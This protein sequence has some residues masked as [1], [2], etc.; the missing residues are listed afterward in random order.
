MLRRH[1]PGAGDAGPGR[2]GGGGGRPR[3]MTTGIRWRRRWL[4]SMQDGGESMAA[5]AV[6]LVAGR[7]GVYGGCRPRCRTPVSRWRRQRSPSMQD[8]GVSMA[9]AV[10][11]YAGRGDD[12]V[13][14]GDCQVRRRVLGQL[15]GQAVYY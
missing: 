4:P 12:N 7:R 9:A 1:R 13:D 10:A 2:P 3:C 8:A 14:G 11:L 15:L 6:A 5:A